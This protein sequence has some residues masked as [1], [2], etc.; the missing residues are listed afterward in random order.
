MAAFRSDC[1]FRTAIIAG[2]GPE[3]YSSYDQ[4]AKR[5][6]ATVLAQHGEKDTFV[7][8]SA[9][10]YLLTFLRAGFVRLP[11][12]A[13]IFTVDD[14]ITIL[15]AHP[16]LR[17][18]AELVRHLDGKTKSRLGGAGLT[19]ALHYL[20]A[21]INPL[22]AS[23]MIA[24]LASCSFHQ[25]DAWSGP[26]FLNQRLI[27][28]YGDG[29]KRPALETAALFI[30]AW[31]SLRAGKLIKAIRY[32]DDEAFPLISGWIYQDGLPIKGALE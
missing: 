26:R 29:I 32:H 22:L 2:V 31:N 30:K 9:L 7:L 13:L 10:S 17:A 25:G 23:E 12:A 8:A 3:A 21:H 20:F 28:D 15:H 19:C 16:D 6:I 24:A 4:H 5:S 1:S 14:Y 27:G 11:G 18:S